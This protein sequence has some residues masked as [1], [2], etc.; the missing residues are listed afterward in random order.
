MAPGH[1]NTAPSDPELGSCCNLGYAHDCHRLP[2]DRQAD[3]VH[4][5]VARDKNGTVEVSWVKVKD[6]AD[7]GHGMLEYDR[8]S[9]RFSAEHADRTVQRMAECY[10]QVY[11]RSNNEREQ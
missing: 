5:C 4:F 10:L 6:H 3:A 7:A 8:A 1:E 9:A 2:I 11:L